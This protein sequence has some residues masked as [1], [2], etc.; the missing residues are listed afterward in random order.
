MNTEQAR[1]TAFQKAG[2][3]EWA[4]AAKK[5]LRKDTIGHLYRKTYEGITLSPLY[6]EADSVP[7]DQFPGEGSYLRGFYGTERPGWRIAQRLVHPD[8]NELK[9]QIGL[10]LQR[11]Q[12][13]LSFDPDRLNDMAELSFTELNG[14]AALN[15]VPLCIFSKTNY[16]AIAKKL[17]EA[18]IS[19]IF[20]AAATDML[21][22]HLEAG[23]IVDD[24]GEEMK[25]WLDVLKALDSQYPE[26]KTILIDLEPFNA[27]GG[28]AGHELGAA[29]AGAVFYVEKMKEMG[30]PPEK[31]AGKFI[32]N[33]AIGSQFFTEIA[34][35]RAFRMLWKMV[36][37]AYGIPNDQNKVLVSAETSEFT[38]SVIDPY[39]NMLRAGSEAFSAVVGGIDFLHVT[40]FDHLT[41][42]GNAFSERIARNTQLLLKDE[43]Y[44]D[45]VMDPA[46]GSFYIESLT[47]EL[48]EKGWA[49]FL[50]IDKHGGI[51]QSLASGW[52][53]HQ[54]KE[55]ALARMRDSETRKQS[56]IG[57]NV[58]ALSSETADEPLLKAKKPTEFDKRQIEPLPR[59]RLAQQFES[60][61]K[62][63]MNLAETGFMPEAALIC[64]GKLKEFKPR[65]DFAAGVLATAGIQSEWSGECHSL[66]DV[67]SFIKRKSYKYYCLC[68]PDALYDQLAAPIGR[69]IKENVP[70]VHIDIAGRFSAE[71]LA[72]YGLDGTLYSGQNIYKKLAGILD[73][74]E[75]EINA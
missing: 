36:A 31:T 50:E 49:F 48:A 15:K 68:G 52:L 51:L 43:S 44:I 46:G 66:S 8:W 56:I 40:P 64:L 47:K 53:Q 21:S 63:S 41:V 55:T 27:G 23:L 24:H 60:L 30:W 65:A 74:W 35:L 25:S 71:E 22:S 42:E 73:S 37:D 5:S 33:F 72:E 1:N 7:A 57:V 39:V 58:Y 4:E 9:K 14:I 38:K 12:D 59:L 54:I 69:W 32:F 67:K 75:D 20:G 16:P 26:L 29:L 19:G 61:R 45:K 62:R 10:S 2:R 28:H 34:K 70:D 11:G 3:E 17:L 6:T 18:H 13:A